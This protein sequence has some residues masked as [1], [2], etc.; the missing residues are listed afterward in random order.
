MTLGVR[1]CCIIVDRRPLLSTVLSSGRGVVEPGAGSA[2]LPTGLPMTFSFGEARAAG[3]S[4]ETL[5]RLV[6]EARLDRLARGLYRRA[7]APLADLDLIAVA[8]R[9]PPATLCLTT[10][11]VEHGLSDA[12][13][14]AADVARPASRHPPTSDTGDR[15][16]ALLRACDLR[17]RSGRPRPGHRDDD[18]LV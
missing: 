12:I 1:A 4:R 8:V 17:Y 6:E 15:P 9:A 16:M 13:P 14:A 7:D 5:S 10:A 3:I 11:L 2:I 18:W